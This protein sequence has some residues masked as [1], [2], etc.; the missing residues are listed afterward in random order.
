MPREPKK[1]TSAA[2][3]SDAAIR[4]ER[5]D[6]AA[7][8]VRRPPLEH[9]GETR[10]RRRT[11]R[12]C[13]RARR[14]PSSR[15]RPAGACRRAA[16]AARTCQPTR[17]ASRRAGG[18]ARARPAATGRAPGRRTRRR[19]RGPRRPRS[20]AAR[21]GGRSSRRPRRGS[22][23]ARAASSRWSWSRRWFTRRPS[24]RATVSVPS[25]RLRREARA[26]RRVADL[27]RGDAEAR[28]GDERARRARGSSRAGPGR[29]TDRHR[30]GPEHGRRTRSTRAGRPGGS[31]RRVVPSSPA[32]TTAWICGVAQERAA[33]GRASAT[34]AATAR[35]ESAQARTIRRMPSVSATP[36]GGPHPRAG[37][38]VTVTHSRTLRAR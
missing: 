17:T 36:P 2:R 33:Y 37:K 9:R 29:R 30:E 16:A 25:E 13:R 8:R 21:A 10:A 24:M 15:T 5:G 34:P 20:A 31:P 1:T 11:A 38:P 7:H 12:A 3:G 35:A 28:G 23:A 18:R 26:R 32:S 22:P 6:L 14:G 4:A 27:A 19:P